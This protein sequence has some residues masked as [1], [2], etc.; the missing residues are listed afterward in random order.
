MRSFVILFCLIAG[1]VSAQ[2]FEERIQVFADDLEACFFTSDTV[3]LQ[4][5]CIGDMAEN[6]MDAEEG[7]HSTL[8]MSM[9]SSAEADV[10]DGLL[11]R[12][13]RETMARAKAAD[14]DDLA[15]FP[16]FANRA[17]ALLEAQRAWIAYRDAE[18]GL[19]YALWG[20]GSMRHI[21]GAGC[22]MDMTAERA[23]ELRALREPFE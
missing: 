4:R 9:C 2:S 15:Y 16:E 10:W 21:A 11:N 6:C 12:E 7:G 22:I 8:G 1:P 19:A 18:C 13:Y 23:I 3:E 5:A 17:K 14:E 20:S